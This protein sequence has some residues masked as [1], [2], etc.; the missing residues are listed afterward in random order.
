MGFG[1][2]LLALMVA[3]L[4]L[5]GC[6]STSH[7]P[8]RGVDYVDLERYMGEWFVIA[9]IPYALEEGKVATLDRY[10]LRED[11]KIDNVFAFREETFEAPE[12]EWKGV[13]WVSDTESNAEWRVQFL[14]PFSASYVI[15]DIDRDYRWAI[16]GHPSRK[17]LW[18]LSRERLMAPGQLEDLIGRAEAQGFDPE[19]IERVPQPAS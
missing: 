7:I 15:M 17:Y 14:W 10:A 1:V 2:K 8:L 6:S 18:I 5:S 12:E 4:F 9:H 13:A 3:T 19:V 16:V 11:G